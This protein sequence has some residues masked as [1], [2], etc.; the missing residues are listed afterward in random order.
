MLLVD[1]L[2]PFATFT[3]ILQTDSSSLSSIIPSILDLECHLQQFPTQ[4]TLTA[5]MQTDLRRRFEVILQPESVGFNP[6]PAAAFLLDPQLAPLLLSPELG[7]LM[8]AAKAYVLTLA[9]EHAEQQATQS[10][11]V[12]TE[13]QNNALGRFK[14]LTAKMQANALVTTS[15]PSHCVDT[16]HGQ[17]NRYISTISCVATVGD[18]KETA[19]AV[20]YWISHN[21]VYSQLAPLAEDL[22]CA[23]ASQ[24]FVERIFSLCGQLTVGRRNRMSRSLEMRV[25]NKLNKGLLSDEPV[26]V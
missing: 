16:V 10:T 13:T 6:L 17:L 18:N 26:V 14:F 7:S 4:K 2:H 25:F 21:D 22:V 24:A 12:V 9:G 15:T 11:T 19:S 3:D 8:H 5:L 23:P 1:L 20:E